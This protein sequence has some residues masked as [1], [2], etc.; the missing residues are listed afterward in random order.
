MLDTNRGE[1]IVSQVTLDLVL[2]QFCW[3]LGKNEFIKHKNTFGWT[4]SLAGKAAKK[5]TESKHY[6]CFRNLTNVKFQLIQK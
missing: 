3:T 6:L 1:K 2:F 5:Q 4:S